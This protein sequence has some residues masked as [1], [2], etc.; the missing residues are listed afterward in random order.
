[1]TKSLSAIAA[2][3]GATHVASFAL[4]DGGYYA[5]TLGAHASGRGGAVVASSDGPTAAAYNPAGLAKVDGIVIQLGNTASYNG[6][7]FT[8]APT[9]DWGQQ[10][11]TGPTVTFDQV[12]NSKPWQAL[13]PL[14]GIASNLGRKDL[15]VG[16]SVLAPPGISTEEFP[17][18]AEQV[19]SNQRYTGGQ[20]YMMVSRQAIIL[21]YV[22]SLAWKYRDL[23]GIGASAQ[24]IHVPRLNYSL[25]IDGSIGAPH[26][27]VTSPEYDI[28]ADLTG[29]SL[30]TFNAT[31]GAWY[32]PVPSFEV[33]FSGQVV[34]ADI[35]AK[36]T[37][38]PWALGSGFAALQD[39]PIPLSR[40]SSGSKPAN[41]VT[42]TLPL[43]L[44][45]RAG[46]RYRHLVAGRQIFDVE[47]DVD[48]TTWS[49]VKQFTIE[50]NGLLANYQGQ[51]PLGTIYVD[52]H[53]RDSIAFRLGGD[54]AVLPGRLTLRAGGYYESA[55]A[56]PAYA[57]VDFPGG[58]QLGGGL[59]ASIFF[60]KLEV[61]IAYQLRVQPTV[62][63]SEKDARVYQ[64]VPASQCEPPYNSPDISKCSPKYLN[65]PSPVVNAGTYDATSHFLALDLVYR[66]AL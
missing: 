25:M 27:P 6:Y 7:T 8:R 36:S 4:A 40:A 18:G 53:W 63:V 9:Q 41:D 21:E 66:Y 26:N 17:Q 60:G 24:W 19:G 64:Q 11:G 1:M 44:V 30:F 65:Q 29:S 12:R 50:T 47:L 13:D 45:F 37:L 22:L 34:P 57:N 51:N 48:Y 54:Y 56:D 33:A 42:V 43:P 62:S 23:F 16:F 55:V 28:R 5:G 61:V 49:R 46:A 20:R 52:K 14:V 32:R 58:P 15:G 59:G 35:V 3:L 31:L 38:T 10:G 2:F 39:H